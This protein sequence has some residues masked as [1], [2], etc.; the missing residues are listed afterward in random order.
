[1]PFGLSVSAEILQKKLQQAL[2]DNKGVV[3]VA[4]CYVMHVM[5]QCFSVQYMS[6][7]DAPKV[8]RPVPARIFVYIAVTAMLWDNKRLCC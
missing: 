1:M 4:D 6:V 3:C 5:W 7:T 2:A 8:E